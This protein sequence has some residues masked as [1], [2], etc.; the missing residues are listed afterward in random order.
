MLSNS[1][2][3]DERAM[4]TNSR[5]PILVFGATGLQGGSVAAGR[6]RRDGLSAH[7]FG[8][9]IPGMQPRFR[10]LVPS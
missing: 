6:S 3:H 2:V 1:S 8:I 9:P 7:S 10:P 5:K 4:T